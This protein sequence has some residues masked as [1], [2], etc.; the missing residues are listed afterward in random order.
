M[1]S[2]QM[3]LLLWVP[4]LG[5][6]MANIS[7][8]HSNNP[9]LTGQLFISGTLSTSRITVISSSVSNSVQL[10]GLMTTRVS[11]IAATMMKE[12]KMV[13]FLTVI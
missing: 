4:P 1:S 13:M 11:S 12:M 8:T 5:A 6:K 9:A 7:L 2:Q 3:V 10:L